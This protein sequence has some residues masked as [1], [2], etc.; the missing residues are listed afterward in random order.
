[1][2]KV[3]YYCVVFKIILGT[4]SASALSAEYPIGQ[5]KVLLTQFASAV[6][7]GDWAPA[8]ALALAQADTVC[9]PEGV[10]SLSSVRIP[11]GKCVYGMGEKTILM[12]LKQQLFLIEGSV[13]KAIPVAQDVSD[14]SQKLVL[15]EPLEPSV[16]H[17]LI[18]SQRNCMVLEDCGQTWALGQTENK[19]RT[20][21]YGE[22]AGI[23]TVNEKTL[24]LK[25][26]LTFPF[27][28]AHN[29]EETLRKNFF[30]RS[31]T[32]V[33]AVFPVKAVTLKSF[34]ILG[35]R[36]AEQPIRLK[37]AFDCQIE[38]VHYHTRELPETL[39]VMNLF[40]CYQSK[41]SRCS[42]RILGPALDSAVQSI[43]RTYADYSRYNM[44]RVISSAHCGFEACF[45]NF[46]TH[47]FSIS[48]GN[49]SIP[50]MSCYVKDCR[51]ENSIWAG[52]VVQQN[53]WKTECVGNTV[54]NAA[55]GV[56]SGG[57]KT[58]IAYNTVITDLPFSTNHYYAHLS[59]GGTSGIALFE[60]F[61]QET[62]IEHNRVQGA[63]T[64]ILITDGYE[65]KNIFQSGRIRIQNNQVSGCLQG[66][67]L[68][69]NPFNTGSDPIDIV[70][71]NNHFRSD[72]PQKCRV[73]EELRS[74][75][76]I[77]LAPRSNRVHI[78]KNVLDH[79]YYGI[80]TGE[81][82]KNITEVEN[83]CLNCVN[84]LKIK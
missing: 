39:C 69:K 27:Y 57:K 44:F 26:A 53:A 21:F 31:S 58:Y 28:K 54:V 5:R 25:N 18:H 12:P 36:Q 40:L 2:K 43:S 72:Y 41:V 13:G 55:Q 74:S 79:F 61:A 30:T 59:R 50:S 70:L 45:C 82:A 78:E 7:Q 63:Y 77:R 80:F 73:G 84:P 81:E 60:G 49:A 3:F 10:Y 17:V 75:F 42:I 38:D 11:S 51:S 52:V 64:G 47:A 56:A 67:Y 15:A 66:F 1:M 29:R 16:Q 46:S 23:D 37:Y 6:Q 19:F 34:L 48:Y 71:E 65:A 35:T 22:F 62:L 4:F 76:G 33:S 32:T 14:F 20:C 83:T 24:R 8:M 68:Y 9:L